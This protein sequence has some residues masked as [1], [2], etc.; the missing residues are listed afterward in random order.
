MCEAGLGGTSRFQRSIA[1]WDYVDQAIGAGDGT[2]AGAAF[3][4]NDRGEAEVA[5]GDLLCSGRG[6]RTIDQRREQIGRAARMHCDIV[7]AVDEPASPADGVILAIGG[8]VRGTVS[9]KRLPAVYERGDH[10]HPRDDIFAH[11]TLRSAAIGANALTTSPTVQLLAHAEGFGPPSQLDVLNLPLKEAASRTSP[12][13][14][15]A[16]R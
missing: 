4:A 8:N 9:L 13:S 1:H 3:V 16:P 5:P 7:V 6:Y 2:A 12:A 15:T 10:L 11:L 14:R